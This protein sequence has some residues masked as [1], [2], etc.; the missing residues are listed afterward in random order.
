[1]RYPR[2]RDA[3]RY[4]GGSEAISGVPGGKKSPPESPFSAWHGVWRR[5]L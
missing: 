1:M 2:F 4:R 3:M 5:L